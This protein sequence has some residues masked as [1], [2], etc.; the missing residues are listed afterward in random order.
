MLHLSSA[1]LAVAERQNLSPAGTTRA[2]VLTELFRRTLSAAP[3]PTTCATAHE[4]RPS[5]LPG[6]SPGSGAMLLVLRLLRQGLLQIG[7]DFRRALL[8]GKASP[9]EELN[10]RRRRRVGAPPSLRTL[11][12]ELPCEEP[13]AL[14][15]DL[16]G[17]GP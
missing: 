13:A 4:L 16:R 3:R 1:A 5:S 8:E 7:M 9:I 14:S 17:A 10:R 12:D 11:S 2:G 6:T 15:D